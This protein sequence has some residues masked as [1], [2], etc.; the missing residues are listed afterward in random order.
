MQ[1]AIPNAD[2]AVGGWNTPFLFD[3]I[4]SLVFPIGDPTYVSTGNTTDSC[5]VALRP[6]APPNTVYL[7]E[8]LAYLAA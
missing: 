7:P 3:K 6:I 2:G 4:N 5:T 1:Y 8:I